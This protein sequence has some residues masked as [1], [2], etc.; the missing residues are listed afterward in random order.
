[1]TIAHSVDVPAPIDLVW[2]VYSQVEHW[3]QWMESMDHVDI[4]DGRALALGSQVWIAQPRMP[5]TTWT[6]TELTPGHSWTWVSRTRGVTATATHELAAV[7]DTTTRVDM[8][9]A[10]S[11][12]QGKLVGRLTGG[13]VHSY[14]EMEARG[15]TEAC[16]FHARS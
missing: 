6:V 10:F 13:R 15:L 7:D 11:G 16:A 14:L 4:M 9:V 12:L 1:M 3:P 8:S 5:A 2:Q